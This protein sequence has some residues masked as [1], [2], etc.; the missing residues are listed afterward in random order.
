MEVLAIAFSADIAQCGG[1][2][3][4]ETLAN[5]EKFSTKAITQNRLV[6]LQSWT[7]VSQSPSTYYSHTYQ[8][9]CLAV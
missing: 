5:C 7:M 9:L 4:A 1:V 2:R 6:H 3:G 8:V